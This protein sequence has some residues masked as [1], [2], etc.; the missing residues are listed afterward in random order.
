[1]IP[2]P[3]NSKIGTV[4]MHDDFFF[5]SRSRNNIPVPDLAIII[6]QSN[7]DQYV[8]AIPRIIDLEMDQLPFYLQHTD[9]FKNAQIIFKDLFGIDPDVLLICAYK[10]DST[11]SAFLFSN[12][13][14]IKNAGSDPIQ[15]KYK[16]H[17]PSNLKLIENK[18]KR[19]NNHERPVKNLTIQDSCIF[20]TL[21]KGIFPVVGAYNDLTADDKNPSFNLI[22]GSYFSDRFYKLNKDLTNDY[23]DES[24]LEASPS[25]NNDWE[26]QIDSELK[27]Q[28]IKGIPLYCVKNFNLK[29]RSFFEYFDPSNMT[30]YYQNVNNLC[31][32]DF[33]TII[34]NLLLSNN[35]G[36][37][38]PTS[39][40]EFASCMPHFYKVDRTE[41]SVRN[42][43]NLQTKLRN[44]YNTSN[45]YG[46]GNPSLNF[47]DFVEF[48]ILESIIDFDLFFEDPGHELYKALTS[49]R[50]IS[51]LVGENEILS[52]FLDNATP[53][54]NYRLFLNNQVNAKTS[55]QPYL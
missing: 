43:T 19:E 29:N 13:S 27:K 30:N 8:C 47:K 9:L 28:F 10:N 44:L 4:L 41:Q 54:N 7:V 35:R 36:S 18:I 2:I 14:F 42:T 51:Q 21:P 26:G 33:A 39:L 22:F 50:T 45:E 11:K 38:L 46:S 5:A 12:R 23:Y 15:F 49:K 24:Q 25:R 48:F 40:E 32:D 37:Y 52:R 3:P 31:A 34:S 53:N 55:V 1:M 17:D 6:N 20:Y 16:P